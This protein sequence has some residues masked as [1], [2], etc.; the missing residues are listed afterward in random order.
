MSSV[1]RIQFSTAIEAPA[2]RVYELMTGPDSYREWASAFFEGSHYV[3]SWDE[4]Q[5]IL[6]LS[7]SG[8][9]MVSEI[10][11]NRINEFISIRHRGFMIQ[12]VEDT[13]SEA[14]KSWAPLYENYTFHAIPEGTQVVIDLD[15]TEDFES[16]MNELWPKALVLLKALCERT[17]PQ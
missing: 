5:R 9:G 13:E 14:V 6:F 10:A 3:G 4:G 8:D 12:G 15:V 1:K 16:D 7:P 11:E 17:V 2:A